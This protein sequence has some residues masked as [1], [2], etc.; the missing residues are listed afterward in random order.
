MGGGAPLSPGPR[1][2]GCVM[3]PVVTAPGVL[4]LALGESLK[5]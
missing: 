4:G 3:R 1:G 5:S 2:Q